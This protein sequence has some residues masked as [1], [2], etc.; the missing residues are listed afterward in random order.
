MKAAAPSG[1]SALHLSD[2]PSS[3]PV[4]QAQIS[5]RLFSLVIIFHIVQDALVLVAFG[6]AAYR[7]TSADLG[8]V[9]PERFRRCLEN[10]TVSRKQTHRPVAQEPG[11]FGS[12]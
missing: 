11:G 8:E 10:N 3:G 1:R 9:E 12:Y 7:L 5:G 6:E 4:T 2:P